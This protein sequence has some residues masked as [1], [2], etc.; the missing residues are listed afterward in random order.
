MKLEQNFQ[1]DLP[2]VLANIDKKASHKSNVE[3]KCNEENEHMRVRKHMKE[4]DR[5]KTQ[6]LKGCQAHGSVYEKVQTSWLPAV[7]GLVLTVH[8]K[9]PSMKS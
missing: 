5:K 4:R 1:Q 8:H 3:R 7:V 2:K 9:R 6:Q